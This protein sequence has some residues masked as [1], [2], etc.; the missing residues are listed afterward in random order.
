M[1]VYHRSPGSRKIVYR[2]GT[3]AIKIDD[4]QE[5]MDC[6]EEFLSIAR[7]DPNQRQI[8]KYKDFR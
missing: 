7:K 3:L 4:L 5:A 8:L 2:L 1:I 6:Y